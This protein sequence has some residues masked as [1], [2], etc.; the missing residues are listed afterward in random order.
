VGA[1]LRGYNY[2]AEAK[3]FENFLIRTAYFFVH[4]ITMDADGPDASFNIELTDPEYV[5]ILLP[6]VF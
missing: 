3:Y 4:S 6:L 5:R 1:C 2:I